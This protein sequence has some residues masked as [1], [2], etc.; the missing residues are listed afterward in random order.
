MMQSCASYFGLQGTILKAVDAHFWKFNDPLHIQLPTMRVVILSAKKWCC[1]K[2]YFH[3]TT[4][5]V[6]LKENENEMSRN[7]ANEIERGNLPV[8]ISIRQIIKVRAK[9]V[10]G[11]GPPNGRK[12][13]CKRL[14]SRKV[15]TATAH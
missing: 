13:S 14:N 8:Q 2:Y 15:T 9:L 4:K 12:F 6:I 1:E 7:F 5:F 10:R 3:K 11:S